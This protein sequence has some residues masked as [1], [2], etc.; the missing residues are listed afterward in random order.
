MIFYTLVYKQ[1]E[2]NIR[3]MFNSELKRANYIK[4]HNI[5]NYVLGE[6]NTL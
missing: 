3:M 5:T 2:D 1:N 6:I 4:N